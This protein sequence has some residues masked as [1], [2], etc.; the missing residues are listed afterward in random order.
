MDEIGRVVRPCPFIIKCGSTFYVTVDNKPLITLASGSASDA[1]LC[2][3][4]AYY[5]FHIQYEKKLEPLFLFIEHH[6]LNKP[7]NGPTSAISK[8]QKFMRL[9]RSLYVPNC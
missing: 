6:M 2:V 1:L 4:S 9:L 7:L 8:V 3:V 5:A